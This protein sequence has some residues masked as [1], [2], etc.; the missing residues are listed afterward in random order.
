MDVL[1]I[2]AHAAPAEPKAPD[3]SGA[4]KNELG[5]EMTLTVQGG[6]LSGRYKSTV[7]SGGKEIEGELTGHVNGDL[8]AF[9]VNWPTAAITAW[10]GQ[11]VSVGGKDNIQTLWQMTTNIPEAQEPKG[12]WHSVY[13]GT[14][15]FARP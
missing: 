11:V 6:K 5:S 13:A 14:D 9:T 15:T 12:L 4:R 3:F 10:V 1:K 8:I 2:L 7:S